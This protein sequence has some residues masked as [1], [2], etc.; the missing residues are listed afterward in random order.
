MATI[1]AE[2]V[3]GCEKRDARGRMLMGTAR[4]DAV[5]AAYDGSNLT[6][7]E[8]AARE[9]VKYNTLVSWLDQRRRQERGAPK[10]ASPVRFE[11]LRMPAAASTGLEVCLPGGV[12]VRGH[13]AVQVAALVR[14]LR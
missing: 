8:F 6:Q 2:L 11:E 14:A 12:I 10:A 7:R 4:R 13:D 3:S 1:S 5:L 9:G